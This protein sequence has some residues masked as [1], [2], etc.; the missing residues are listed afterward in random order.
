MQYPCGGAPDK[1]LLTEGDLK[2]MRF[3]RADNDDEVIPREVWKNDRIPRFFVADVDIRDTHITC[4]AAFTTNLV[5]SF[6]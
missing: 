4:S 5:I 6:T 2:E 3:I 1:S